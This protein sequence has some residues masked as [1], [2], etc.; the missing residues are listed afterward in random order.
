MSTDESFG[1]EAAYRY[2][3]LRRCAEAG[4]SARDLVEKRA[5]I[6]SDLR[7]TVLGTY[8]ALTLG[9]VGLGAGTGY[10]LQRATAPDYD[11]ADLRDRELIDT[12]RA[13]ARDARARA[14]ARKLKPARKPT[15]LSY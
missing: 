3:F 2:G 14:L 8:G 11:P 9:A 7:D 1:L 10:G 6:I 5:S 4:V 13:Y 15:F 12:Y